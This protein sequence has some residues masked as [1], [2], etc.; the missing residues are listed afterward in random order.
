MVLRNSLQL[1]G[2]VVELEDW[3]FFELEEDWD[4]L[5]VFEPQGLPPH[6]PHQLPHCEGFEELEELEEFCPL[7][8]E[9]FCAPTSVFEESRPEFVVLDGVTEMGSSESV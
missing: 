4:E 9:F 3:M 6:W 7:E 5:D 1:M 8:L 2:E